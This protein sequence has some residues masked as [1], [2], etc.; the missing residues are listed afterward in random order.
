VTDVKLVEQI[1]THQH[2]VGLLAHY[3][4]EGGVEVVNCAHFDRNQNRA[5][6]RSRDLRF[7]EGRH[8]GGI[9][10]IGQKDHTP[11]VPDGFAQDLQP[12]GAEVGTEHGVARDVSARSGKALNQADPQRDAW[13]FHNVGVEFS[14][15]E[16][17]R[18][19]TCELTDDCR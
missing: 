9:V 6:F 5:R 15:G 4:G 16:I 13:P 10:G 14:L 3:R 2:G 18:Y 7:G 12:F 19:S 17:S 11:H 1:V 8:V